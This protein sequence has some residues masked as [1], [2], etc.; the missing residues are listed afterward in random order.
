MSRLACATLT[1]AAVLWPSCAVTGAEKNQAITA[2][3]HRTWMIADTV[4]EKHVDPPARQAMLLA[5]AKRLLQDQ[6]LPA[7][8]DLSRRVSAVVTEP[9]WASLLAVLLERRHVALS[10][11][12]GGTVSA[13]LTAVPGGATVLTADDIKNRGI[14]SGNRYVGTGIQIRRTAD[15]YTQIVLPFAG[16]P[17]RRAGARPGDVI[18]AVDGVSMKDHS[19]RD[20]VQRVG[21]QE[22]KPV[23]L[24]VRQPASSVTRQLYMIRAVVPFDNVEGYRRTGETS[25]DY[26]PDPSAPIA[27]LSISSL[28]SSTAHELRERERRLLQTG[29]QALVLDLRGAAGTDLHHAEQVAGILLNAGPVWT[30]RDARGHTTECRAD[31]DS[32]FRDCPIAVIVGKFTGGKPALLADVLRERRHAVLV[33]QPAQADLWDRQTSKLPDELGTIELATGIVERIP[34]ERSARD[35]ELP[36]GLVRPDEVVETTAK[37]QA[38]QFRWRQEQVS[39]EPVQGAMKA[40]PED[41]TLARALDVLRTR[42]KKRGRGA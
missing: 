38:D 5:A 40:P 13:M 24:T 16:G 29:I 3:A 28:S 41:R 36:T 30:V 26:R 25:W 37:E 35:Q 34:V 32:L 8:N 7:P 18:M 17:A 19:I 20:V 2:L 10:P 39:P 11:D 4:L 15:G 23:T 14:V 42:L 22:G 31:G 6:A 21:G 27:Y 1:C 9:Q 12:P 33:G